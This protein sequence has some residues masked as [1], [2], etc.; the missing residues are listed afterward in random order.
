MK[1]LDKNKPLIHPNCQIEKSLFGSFVEIGEY[2]IVSNT[3]FGDYSYCTRFCDI[4]NTE[5]KKFSNI[6]SSVRI[7]PTDHPM[8]KA[9]L[10]HFLYR[11]NDYWENKEKDDVF[12]KKRFSRK[13]T[14]GN[15]TWIGHGAIIKPEIIIGDGAIIIGSGSVVTKNV[16][17]YTIV[18]GNP[19]KVI[20]RRF[21]EKI[22]IQL[23]EIQWW[24]W[25]H[26]KLGSS[27]ED[28]RNLRIEDF[29]SKYK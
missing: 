12:F 2:S 26:E 25:P 10:H 27:L 21:S 1:K 17:S 19:A 22:A 20:R 29:I 28:F 9:S 11:S 24:N 13:T 6:A 16:E 23:S 3:I 15:D 8:E 4:A 5:I 14:I 7:G 18:A